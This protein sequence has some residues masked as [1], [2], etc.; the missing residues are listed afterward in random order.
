[1]GES[2]GEPISAPQIMQ[3]FNYKHLPKELQEV[4]K[5]F[6][7]LAWAMNARLVNNDEKIFCLR[8]LL[9]AKDAAVRSAL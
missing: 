9:L 2:F 4:S 7:E 6:S 5:P 3:Y 8:Q 1:M